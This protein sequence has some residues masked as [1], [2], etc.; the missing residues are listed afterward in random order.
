M[1][2]AVAGDPLGPGD[3]G[4]RSWS[5]A[6]V[7]GWYDLKVTVDGD[8]QFTYRAAGHVENGEDSFSDPLMGGLI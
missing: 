6:R 3:S 4:T 2:A 1:A 7:S 8:S 5:L